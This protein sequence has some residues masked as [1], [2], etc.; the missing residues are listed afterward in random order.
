[1]AGARSRLGCGSGFGLLTTAGFEPF[2]GGGYGW[3][4]GRGWGRTGGAWNVGLEWTAKGY[5]RRV[6]RGKTDIGH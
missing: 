1:M 2:A 3:P 6:G 5:G 4:A